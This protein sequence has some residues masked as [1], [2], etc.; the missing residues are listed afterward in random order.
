MKRREFITLLGGAVAW[1]FAACP[2]TQGRVH[3][4]GYLHPVNISVQSLIPKVLRPVRQRLGYVEGETL[5]LRSAADLS[6][7]PTLVAELIDVGV[8]V[9]IVVGPAAIRAAAQATKTMPI[10]A[11]DLETDPIRAGLAASVSRPGG[12]VTGLFLDQPSLAGK[13]L[14]GSA[15]YQA[16][17]AYLGPNFRA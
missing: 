15:Q 16:R 7:L 4:I 6:R 17:R 11:I 3:K 1:P 14:Q 9:L 13:W 8:G 12:N 10:V 2:Q 5:F